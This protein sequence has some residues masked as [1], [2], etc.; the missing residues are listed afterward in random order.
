MLTSVLY[1]ACSLAC[2]TVSI[3]VEHNGASFPLVAR[4]LEYAGNAKDISVAAFFS[5]FPFNCSFIPLLPS[6]QRHA[7]ALLLY[8]LFKKSHR[9]AQKKKNQ[10]KNADL[11]SLHR[12]QSRMH[13][14]LH[15]RGAQW[16][17]IP[18]R[19]AHTRIRRQRERHLRRCVFFTFPFQL[20][21]YSITPLNATTCSCSA[22]LYI[23]FKKSHRKAQ[24]KNQKKC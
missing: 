20:L 7:V 14:C 1:T 3:P 12:V 19:R 17:I 18:S 8:I 9:K 6:M 24:K 13:H 21:F 2:T 15:P 5:L 23:L 4:T 22:L 11:C 16:R 10:K